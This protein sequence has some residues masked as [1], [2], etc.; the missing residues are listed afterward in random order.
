MGNARKPRGLREALKKRKV[1]TTV[2]RIPLVPLEEAQQIRSELDLARQ[3][4]SAGEFLKAQGEAPQPDV[5]QAI[6][7]AGEAVKDLESRLEACFFKVEFRGLPAEDF[8]ALVQMHPPTEDQLDEA[9]RKGEEPAMWN[10]ETFYPE[11][12]ER[13]AVSSELSA[14]EWVEELKTWPRA[15]RSEIRSRALEA[16]VRSYTTALGFG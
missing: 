7:A 16:N 15:E 12:L 8:D 3:T 1:K 11:L 13:C 9:R 4:V 10:E 14:A 5:L 2:Y 6:A